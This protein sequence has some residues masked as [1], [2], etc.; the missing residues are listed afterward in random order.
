MAASMGGGIRLQG[1]SSS[2][3]HLAEMLVMLELQLMSIFP[4]THLDTGLLLL[5]IFRQL[6]IIL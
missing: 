6:T 2:L 1:F 3:P 4:K 5:C